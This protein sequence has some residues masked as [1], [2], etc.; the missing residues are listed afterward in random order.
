MPFHQPSSSTNNETSSNRDHSSSGE[1]PASPQDQNWPLDRVQI[2]LAAHAFSKEWQDAL[3][4]LNVHGAQ[5]LDIGKVGGQRNVGF[6]MQTVLPQVAR[7]CTASGGIWDQAK[8]R[9]EAKRLRRLVRDVISTGGASTP[10]SSTIGNLPLR[11][12]RRESS[13]FG[14]SAG[15]DGT[16]ENSPDLARSNNA[17]AGSTPST[18]GG[19]GDDS[20]GLHMPTIAQRRYSNTHPRAHTYD[21]S[22]NDSIR[23]AMTKELLGSVND[24]PKRHSPNASGEVGGGQGIRGFSSSPQSSPG[25]N[26]AKPVPNGGGPR[27]YSHNRGVSSETNIALQAKSMSLVPGRASEPQRPDGDSAFAKPPPED[28]N[29]RRNATDSSRPPYAEHRGSAEA[30]ASALGKEHKRG[31]LDK[32]KR[33][34]KDEAHPSPEDE[35][36]PASPQMARQFPHKFP[37]HQSSSSS[38]VDRPPSRNRKHESVETTNSYFTPPASMRSSRQPASEKDRK[39]IFVTPDGW[40][41]RL[42]DITEIESAEMLRTVICYNLGV[43]ESSEVTVHLTSPGQTEH[44]EALSDQLLMNARKNVADATGSLRLYVRTASAT[45]AVPDSAGLG[46]QIPQSPFGR[47]S[48]SDR[49]LD[50]L[51]YA[52]LNEGVDSALAMPDKPDIANLPDDE[53]Q[54][55]L[56]AKAEEHRREMDRRQKAYLESRRSKIETGSGKKIHDFDAPRDS[57]PGSS[58]SAD[59]DRKSDTLVPMRKPPPVPEPTSTLRKADSL[60]KKGGPVNMVRTS[61]P[62]RK[63]EWKRN[64]GGSIPEEDGGKRTNGGIGSALAGMG[65]AARAI[66][67]PSSAPGA[68]SAPGVPSGLQKSETAPILPVEA[69]RPEVRPSALSEINFNSKAALGGRASPGSPK[70]P[71]THSK[72]GQMFKIP[73]YVENDEGAEDDEDTLKANQ[74]NLKLSIPANPTVNKIKKASSPDLSPSSAPAPGR[75][76]RHSTKRG[77]SFQLP[78]RQVDFQHSPA[79]LHEESEDSDDGLFAVP[80]KRQQQKLNSAKTPSSARAQAVLGITS[81]PTNRSPNRPELKV[82][83]SKSN[84]KF[85]S[86]LDKKPSEEGESIERHVP[87]SAS[88]NQYST[89]SPEDFGP[90]FGGRRESFASDMWANRPPAE[91]IVEHL[92]EFFPNVDLDQPVVEEN[93]ETAESSPAAPDKPTLSVKTSSQDLSG[94]SRSVTPASSADES[95][96]LGSDQ[97]TLKRGDLQM[98]VAQRNMRRAGGGLGRT[99]SIRDVVKTNYNMQPGPLHHLSTSSTASSRVG[100]GV[101]TINPPVNR[102]S[103]L[104]SDGAAG[105]VRRKSTKMFGARIEQVKPARGSRLINNLETIP[106]DTIPPENITH[107]NQRGPERQPTFKW[108]RGQLIGKGTFGRVYLGMNTTT[109]ELLAVKQVEVSHNST[110]KNKDDP[111]KIKEMVKALDIEI[112][113]MKDLDHVNIVQYLGC[114]KKEFSISIFLEYISG[115]SVGSCLR[116]HG[117]FEVSVVSS[118]TRQTL[119][120]LAY[121]HGEGILHRDLKADNILLDLDGTCKISDFGISKRSANPYNNDITNSMQGSVFWM[122]PEVIRAQS[123]PGGALTSGDGL[124]ASNASLGY[125]AKVDIW[126]LGCVVLEMFAGRRPWSKE[127]AIGA[128]YKLGSLNQAPPIPDD[129]SSVV[130]PAA[131]SFMYDCF[132]M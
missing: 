107:V 18:A 104:R 91:G 74:P 97:S 58:G 60:T 28:S 131:L 67:T 100:S 40:N 39:F 132:T 9:E 59:L 108:M 7:E 16:L 57:R 128:I 94:N 25:L 48:I 125:S 116:K 72:G 33:T 24:I 101:P 124:G 30:P 56:E 95:D 47:P 20:P 98:S 64:S 123:Q 14:V 103:M 78:E 41:Y 10:A 118:L 90:G 6:M 126:S 12:N 29:R 122:A 49:P 31:F 36:S 35:Q 50:P 11:A 120:G 52:K 5:F 113:T 129:V 114:E 66:G 80:L 71:F 61:W 62:N 65:M 111:A 4:H 26:N 85:E 2:W 63:E 76:N 89:D 51:T 82:K 69:R 21:S 87:M 43:Q 105:I 99:K 110:D 106:Q 77:P 127:E 55:L 75:L 19:T 92:D 27:Y 130:G 17:L 83:T 46:L 109:G 79:V 73:D 93:G 37:T 13:Q 112:D 32:F 96:T 81:G 34:K 44:E 8:E 117:R 3:R 53:R 88:S 86:P 102:V 23:S 119:N 42:I 45:N 68:P 54:A 84:V 38:L 121:L 70:S 15:A 115:G 22:M 1:T